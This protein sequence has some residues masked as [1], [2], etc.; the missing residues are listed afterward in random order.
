MNQPGLECYVIR[1]DTA[2]DQ[3]R[4]DV[5]STEGTRKRGRSYMLMYG[6]GEM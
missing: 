1:E 5:S 4:E 3:G 6:L 2:G